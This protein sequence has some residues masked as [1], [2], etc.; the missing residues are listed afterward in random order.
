VEEKFFMFSCFTQKGV[1]SLQMP[2]LMDATV[3]RSLSRM[4]YIWALR[5]PVVGYVQGF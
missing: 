3:Q 5:H 1:F 4:L 2:L